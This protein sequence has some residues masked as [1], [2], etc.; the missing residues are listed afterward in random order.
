MKISKDDFTKLV[1]SVIEESMFVKRLDE[2]YPTVFKTRTGGYDRDL[3]NTVDREDL[4]YAKNTGIITDEDYDNAILEESNI[5]ASAKAYQLGVDARTALDTDNPIVTSAA[6]VMNKE[7]MDMIEAG[8][9]MLVIG[10]EYIFQVSLCSAWNNYLGS[11]FK[12]R[13][14]PDHCR[15]SICIYHSF[16]PKEKTF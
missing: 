2:K 5:D 13:N 10:K 1:K 7:F 8:E 11:V 12:V 15:G 6:P 9:Q 3:L 14:S 4:E 16:A